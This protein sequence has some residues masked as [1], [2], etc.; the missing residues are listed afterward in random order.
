LLVDGVN[1]RLVGDLYTAVGNIKITGGTSGQYLRTDGTGNLSWHNVTGG[2]GASSLIDLTDVNV[3]SPNAG[4][5]LAWN[6]ADWINSSYFVGDTAGSVFADDSTKLVDG[7]IGKL[8]GDYDNSYIKITQDRIY[9]PYDAPIIFTRD[10]SPGGQRVEFHVNRAS[11]DI[12][13][14]I[15]TG[16]GGIDSIRISSN[17]YTPEMGELSGSIAIGSNFPDSITFYPTYIGS[18]V[19]PAGV[20]TDPYTPTKFFVITMPY[21]Q[22]EFESRNIKYL[23]FDSYGRMAINKENAQATLDIGGCMKMDILSSE[24][25]DL[26]DGLIAIANGTSWNPTGSGKKTMVVRLG[27]AWV[28]VASAA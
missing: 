8:V 6:G 3:L 28:S 11:T 1:G 22:T 13:N 7:V 27:G 15:S 21:N 9:P 25:T 5:V 12:T 4:Q 2:S 24:P 20:I 18:Q 17:A 26:Y 10:S 23:T 14:S 19:D 16:M